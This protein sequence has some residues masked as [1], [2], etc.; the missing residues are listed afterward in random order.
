MNIMRF[1]ALVVCDLGTGRGES[2]ER[3]TTPNRRAEPLVASR[4]GR[5]RRKESFGGRGRRRFAV[6]YVRKRLA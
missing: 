4:G 1:S 6:A 5:G 3:Q 2:R